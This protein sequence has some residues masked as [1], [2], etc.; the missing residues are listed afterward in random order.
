MAKMIHVVFE[1][2]MPHAA[3]WNGRWSGEGEGHYIFRSFPE[4][5]RKEIETSLKN[6]PWFYL[7]GDGWG[8]RVSARIIDGQ[9]KRNLKKKNAGF[10]GYGWMVEDI[11]LYGEIGGR[12]K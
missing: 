8:A 10:C 5:R 1:L 7:C 2:T 6:S 4:R 11:L 9:K 3:S 12:R